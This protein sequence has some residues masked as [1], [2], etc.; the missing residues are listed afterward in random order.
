MSFS[1]SSKFSLT[2]AL[3]AYHPSSFEEQDYKQKML[4]LFDV[5]GESCFLRTLSHAHF[6]ASAWLVDRKA[7]KALLTHHKKLNKWLQV[8]GHADGDQHLLRVAAK[9]L[10]EES[11]LTNFQSIS[12]HIFDV[13]IHT[14]PSRKNEP[15]HEHFDVR[16]LFEADANEKLAPNH[17]SK[18][19]KWVDWADI[20]KTLENAS[21]QRMNKKVLEMFTTLEAENE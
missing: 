15:T 4:H 6:T 9:E 18:A 3:G 13:D 11:G 8:G 10:Q 19:M 17:E 7:E 16:F 20:Q 14:I 12:H 21:I 2:E 1:P 5:H